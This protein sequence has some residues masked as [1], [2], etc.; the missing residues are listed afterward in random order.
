MKNRPYVS[1][2]ERTRSLH[3]TNYMANKVT[4]GLLKK[5]LIEEVEIKIGRRGR[6][7]KYYKLT[8]QSEQA[9][10]PQNLGPGKG[11]FEH[12]FHQQRLQRRFARLGYEAKIEDYRNGKSADIGLVKNGRT[13]AIEIAMSPQG[14]I[15]NIVKDLRAGW[16]EV[17]V[18]CR[19]S[20]VLQQVEREWSQ[21]PR[22][23][24]DGKVEFRLV[25]DPIFDSK[26]GEVS[27]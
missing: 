26:T 1:T 13:L 21:E 24:Q 6:A 8:K 7:A 2:V 15:V 4:R 23:E 20:K 5:Q 9:I 16:D 11:G 14:E 22:G 19:D 17:W 27:I 10:G 12:V 25:S 3:L 18:V